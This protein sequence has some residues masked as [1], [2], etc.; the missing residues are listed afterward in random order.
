[1]KERL[2]H[3]PHLIDI[4]TIAGLNEIAVD[5]ERRKPSASARWPD[6][7]IDRAVTARRESA[8]RGWPS[9]RQQ[10]P[11]S[12]CAP[13]ARIGG[14]LCFAEPHSDPAT[15]LIAW[16]ASVDFTVRS[17]QATREDP[18]RSTS[19]PGCSETVRDL[20]DSA[21]R[22]PRFLCLQTLRQPPTSD[23]RSH[24]RP[25]AT[26]AADDRRASNP[27]KS[28]ECP[29][30]GRRVSVREPE[31]RNQ[32]ADKPSHR[33]SNQS[34]ALFARRSARIVLATEWTPAEDAF[35]SADYKRQLSRGVDR[36]GAA[37][38]AKDWSE[39]GRTDRSHRGHGRER[40]PCRFE[41]P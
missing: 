30:R 7:R 9:W 35:E 19:S 28:V 32:G 25:T 13:P 4:K 12:A 37:N 31:R 29:D 34:A 14:N 2:A 16:D 26:V 3:F 41:S 33:T 38:A 27:A 23:S 5:G 11:T 10:S 21:D 8:F 36:S 15:L 20:D 1:M 17:Q 24:E 40:A 22:D 6:P 18:G 39:K